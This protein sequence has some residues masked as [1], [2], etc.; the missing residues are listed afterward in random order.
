MVYACVF[1]RF[2]L[3]FLGQA[4]ED[5][6]YGHEMVEGLLQVHPMMM[7]MCPRCPTL[8]QQQL[9]HVDD[10]AVFCFN[11]PLLASLVLVSCG[12]DLMG[13]RCITCNA[14]RLAVLTEFTRKPV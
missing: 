7:L 13:T 12:V 9:D 14:R 4:E 1:V 3:F 5:E 11:L 10:G 2:S 8:V 6:E